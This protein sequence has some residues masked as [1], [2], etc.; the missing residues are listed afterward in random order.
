MKCDVYDSSSYPL[1][2]VVRAIRMLLQA[3]VGIAMI[4]VAGCSASASL[5]TFASSGGLLGTWSKTSYYCASSITESLTTMTVVSFA[6]NHHQWFSLSTGKSRGQDTVFV[7]TSDPL[8]SVDIH[9]NACRRF[10]VRH[11]PQPGG[12]LGADVE[13]D[14]DTGDGGRVLASLHAQSC[15]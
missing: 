3:L 6:D 9:K 7:E 12:R 4:V 1:D 11:I 15:R 8:R 5:G 10:E 14:C 13:L 2:P